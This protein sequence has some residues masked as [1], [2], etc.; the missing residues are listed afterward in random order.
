MTMQGSAP[1]RHSLR[2]DWFLRDPGGTT[3]FVL[4][5]DDGVASPPATGRDGDVTSQS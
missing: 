3:I 5:G 1:T 4:P 2:V